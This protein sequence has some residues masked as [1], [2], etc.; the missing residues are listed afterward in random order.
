MDAHSLV[1]SRALKGVLAVRVAR[2]DVRMAESALA[3]KMKPKAD[4]RAA[5]RAGEGAIFL[6]VGIFHLLRLVEHWPIVVGTTTV[7]Y[8]LSYV[9]LPGSTAYCVW[10]IWLLSRDG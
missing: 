8:A 5:A 3:K 9:G 7:P 6:L 2:G 1:L 10:A 4:A